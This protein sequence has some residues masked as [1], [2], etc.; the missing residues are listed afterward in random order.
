MNAMRPG[1]V[2]PS[3]LDRIEAA[4]R[5]AADDG[6]GTRASLP[7]VEA[8]LRAALAAGGDRRGAIDLLAADALLTSACEDAAGGEPGTLEVFAGEATRRLAALLDTEAAR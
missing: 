3:L 6:A 8:C 5:S 4:L 2:P 1:T 7:A